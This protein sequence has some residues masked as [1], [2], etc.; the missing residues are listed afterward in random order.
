[1]IIMPK[2]NSNFTIIQ[3]DI[4]NNYPDMSAK[5]KFM[6]LQILSKP[7]DWK[8][9]LSWLAKQNN[10]GIHAVKSSVKEWVDNG[11][12]H[13]FTARA[14]G[15]IKEVVPVVCFPPLTREQAEAYFNVK[16]QQ[17]QGQTEANPVE[18]EIVEHVVCDSAI[19]ETEICRQEINPV[20][21]H[22][23]ENH[24][25]LNT[26]NNKNKF[27]QILRE[28]T[29]TTPEPDSI[30]DT[31]PA[32]SLPSSSPSNEILNLIPEKH[33][34]PMV[35][36][37][38]NKAMVDYPVREVEEAIAYAGANV[39]GG[40]MQFKAYLDKTLKNGW[41]AGYFDS[42][43]EPCQQEEVPWAPSASGGKF[44]NGFVTGSRRMDANLAACL[45]FAAYCENRKEAT[46]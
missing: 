22:L 40:S 21:N 25:L 43:L 24:T 44:A 20:E 2:P 6:L 18:P 17:S 31:Y 36:S 41:S 1:M 13:K 9:N 4:F 46:A 45:E 23:E 3:N 15:R 37:L 8:L 14:D 42:I 33:K 27:K 34:N 30:L 26:D 7:A 28:T 16:Y 11:F 10:E 32:M 38:V 12:L 5:S 19:Y 29:T 35:L 39:R